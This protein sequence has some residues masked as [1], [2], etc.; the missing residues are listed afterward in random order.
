M[1]SL[2]PTAPMPPAGRTT[3]ARYAAA[4]APKRPHH[5]PT[6]FG[7]LNPLGDEICGAAEPEAGRAAH[8]RDFGFVQHSRYP[9][10]AT[11][12]DGLDLYHFYHAPVSAVVG[13]QNRP[14]PRLTGAFAPQTS[15]VR[16]AVRLLQ[17]ERAQLLPRRAGVES[18][19]VTIASQALPPLGDP[20]PGAA[21]NFTDV[22]GPGV[23]AAGNGQAGARPATLGG[24]RQAGPTWPPP[25][26][27]EPPEQV[28]PHRPWWTRPA[29][30][31]PTAGLRPPILLDCAGWSGLP[32]ARR[33][34]REASSTTL[35]L[36]GLSTA[37]VPNAG[38]AARFGAVREL[39]LMQCPT[40]HS[41]AGLLEALPQLRR[42][43]V[44]DCPALAELGYAPDVFAARVTLAGVLGCP[45]FVAVDELVTAAGSPATRGI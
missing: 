20:L 45:A 37:V 11:H 7:E 31:A 12:W 8:R 34:H 42:L 14:S 19:P 18:A 15:A 44:F 35:R 21:A 28:A 13:G 30:T 9:T 36:R 4:P 10:E 25:A 43:Y 27:P 17:H 1:S 33:P 38:L 29:A 6:P 41:F 40:L 16:H 24:V 26:L 32:P 3:L 2:P 39:W 23:R 5:L 22:P